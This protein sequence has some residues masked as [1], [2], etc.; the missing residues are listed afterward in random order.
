M[1]RHVPRF[2]RRFVAVVTVLTVLTLGV[3]LAVVARAVNTS[4]QGQLDEALLTEARQEAEESARIGGS[5]L[6]ISDRPGPAPDDIGH[7]TKYAAIYDET[8]RTLA[9]TA[10][11]HGRPPTWE[12]VQRPPM[13]CFD[14]YF[15]REHLRGVLVPIPGH[16]G[17][18]LLLAAPRFDLDRDAAFL[19]RAVF[20]VLVA[21]AFWTALVT[22]WVVRRLT[23]GHE[24]IAAV[25]RQVA[26]GDLSA[27]VREAASDQEMLQLARDVNTMIE[28]L[29]TLL[30]SQQEFVAHAAHELRSPLTTLYGELSLAL[31]RSRDT[32]GYRQAIEEALDSARRLKALAEDLLTLARLG[33]SAAQP[34]E[35][36]A[37]RAI[38][39]EAA[40]A[41]QSE[42]AQREVNL[43][44]D[45]DGGLIVGR[46]NDLE[47]L[48]RNLLEN[49]IRHSPKGGLVEA[50]LADGGGEV[51]VS[52]T[53]EGPGV[54]DTDRDY[55]F[56][57]FYRGPRETA[58][59]LPGFGLGLAI[60]RKIARSHGGD[61]TLGPKGA[62]GAQF[63][64]RL[65]PSEP[66]PFL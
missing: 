6:D 3:A 13:Q 19:N 45:G 26:A 16:E 36:V 9:A 22:A 56:E 59:D 50:R 32:E 39:D 8:G 63:I 4:Q 5:Q 27:R 35:E 38:L 47:R 12:A 10:T 7:L 40:R 48:F 49:A 2:Q 31:R 51:I 62:A 60:A 11:F 24:A 34:G 28:R 58:D 64:V 18:L 1:T 65:P 14:L 29:S 54:A 17:T 53:D 61:V 44:V 21:S 42:A 25:A 57:P 41:V 43:R 52:V 66:T 33:A 15:R 30:A 23:R 20:V 55:I 46:A 37:A